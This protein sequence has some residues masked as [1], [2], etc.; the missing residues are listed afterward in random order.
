[1][2]QS[3]LIVGLGFLTIIKDPQNA[4]PPREVTVNVNFSAQTHVNQLQDFIDSKIEK[5]RKG[6]YGPP[7]GK[8]M[9]HERTL[10][11]CLR[12]QPPA[13]SQSNEAAPVHKNDKLGRILSF[14][15]RVLH[16]TNG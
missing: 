12:S 16:P 7:M 2:L 11:S 13:D 10:G 3:N 8:K 9:V 5:R 14:T 15:Y 6:I 1:M 4:P